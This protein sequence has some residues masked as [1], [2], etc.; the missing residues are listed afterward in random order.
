MPISRSR[1]EGPHG[2]SGEQTFTLDEANGNSL[3]CLTFALLHFDLPLDPVVYRHA[4]GNFTGKSIFLKCSHIDNV[5]FEQTWSCYFDI[6]V[7]K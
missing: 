4:L 7:F 1:G 3:L 2:S 6:V 5:C